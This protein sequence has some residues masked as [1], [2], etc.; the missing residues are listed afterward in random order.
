MTGPA[1]QLSPREAEAALL[2]HRIP[3]A[4]RRFL[5]VNCGPGLLC[6]VAARRCKAATTGLYL[7]GAPGDR[8]IA[9]QQATRIVDTLADAAQ[10]APFD[11]IAI[12]GLAPADAAAWVQQAGQFLASEGVIVVLAGQALPEIVPDAAVPLVPYAVW[13][14]DHPQAE[15]EEDFRPAPGE[16]RVAVFGHAAYDPIAHAQR[17]AA[18]RR[19]DQAYEILC[20][21]PPSRRADPATDARVQIFKMVCLLGL[22]KLGAYPPLTCLA[23]GLFLFARLQRAQP[24]QPEA[25]R[26]LARFWEAV[27]G[28]H[29]AARLRAIADELEDKPHG[30]LPAI[31]P[32]PAP[33]EIVFPPDPPR[34][35]FVAGNARVNYG[36]DVLYHG[37]KRVLGEDN[38]VEY[39]Y[40]PTLHGAQAATFAHYPAFFHHGGEDLALEALMAA[41]RDGR[42]THIAWGDTEMELPREAAR[43]IRAAG[44]KLPLVLVDM[45]DDCADH[46]PALLEWLALDGPVSCFKRECLRAAQYALPTQCLP[47]AY[48]DDLVAQDI[49]APRA[50]P[51]LWAGQRGWGLRDLFLP[52]L[53]RH[54]IDTRA[55]YTQEAY[56]GVLREAVACLSLAGAGFD[57]VRYWEAPANGCLLL[58]EAHPLALPHDFTDGRDALFFGTP[59]ELEERLQWLDARPGEAEAIRHAG[60][61]RLRARHTASARAR[62]LVGSFTH[63]PSPPV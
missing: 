29:S 55:T 38:V 7:G 2:Q 50:R 1:G 12:T 44:T 53:D 23:A 31:E 26:L 9:A 40:K 34:V 5:H 14:I 4:T 21:V 32:L 39:P 48:P 10:A 49:T 28:A 33:P 16:P 35:L 8:A 37:L 45:Q 56:R 27:P 58:A 36:L 63:L 62:Q 54:G 25:L 17:L 42:F 30:P 46:G 15:L 41:L 59:A 52:I 13:P 20:T 19:F 47:F 18:V 60:H 43:A 22:Q 57:T 61:A 3:L 11:C 51:I 6:G 24:N